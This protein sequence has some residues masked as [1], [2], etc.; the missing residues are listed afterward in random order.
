[1]GK[2]KDLL[3][4]LISITGFIFTV[5]FGPMLLMLAI[6]VWKF[7]V[8][9]KIGAIIIGVFSLI[10]IVTLFIWQKKM[11]T[12][13]KNNTKKNMFI[14]IGLNTFIFVTMRILWGQL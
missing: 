5:L 1:M 8:F 9:G 6:Y 12:E 3:E 14:V 4:M 11:L 13:D 7:G 2:N 10:N